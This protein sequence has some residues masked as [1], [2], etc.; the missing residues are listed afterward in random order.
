METHAQRQ[1]RERIGRAIQYRQMRRTGLGS[2]QA[3]PIAVDAAINAGI[4][5]VQLTC[6]G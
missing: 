3:S 2:R 4:I 6:A 1:K 5:P